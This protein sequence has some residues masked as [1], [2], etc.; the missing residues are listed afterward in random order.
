MRITLCTVP[1]EPDY[2]DLTPKVS[3]ETDV[4]TPS[5]RSEGQLPILPKIAIVSIVKWMESHGYGRETYDYYDIDM[6]LPSDERLERYFRDYQPAVVGLSAVVST[7]YAQVRRIS[8]ILRAAC[9]DAWIVLGGS[10]TASANLV[11]RKTDVDVCVVGDGEIAWV[12]FLDYVQV[13]GGKWNHEVLSKI[14]GLA[15]LD[16]KDELRMTGYGQ[17]IPAGDQPFPDYDILKLGLKDR[18]QDLNNFFRKGLGVTHFRSDPRTFEGHQRPNVAGLWSSKGCVARCTFC[19]RSTKGYRV[20]GIDALESHLITL[21]ERF[22]VGFIHIIDENFASDLN[23]AYEL[24]RTMKRHDM[25]WIASGV[26]VSSVKDEDVKFFKEHGCCCLKFGVETGSQKIMNVMEKKFTVERV[27]Q[28]LKHC[29]D[30]DMYSPLAVMV[31]MP[32]ETNETALATGRFV[33]RLSHMQGIEPEYQG[34]SIFYALPLTGTPLYVHGQQVGLIG[35]SPEEEE[36]YL[37]SVSGTG[38]SKVNYVNLNG[39]R[40]RDVVFWDWL[41]KLEASR[42]FFELDRQLPINRSRFFYRALVDEKKGEIVGRPLTIA[43]VVSKHKAG[44]RTGIKGRLFNAVDNFLDRHVVYNRRVLRLPRWLLFGAVKN[45]VFVIFLAQKFVVKMAGR[46]FN[47]Y[48][49]RPQV[50]PLKVGAQTGKVEIRTS[51]RT[52]VKEREAQR[53]LPDSVTEQNQDILAVGL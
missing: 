13:H 12:E 41:V 6:E 1:V 5:V 45:L 27:Y 50:A 19:Q 38:A 10:L 53:A 14:R 8:R 47:L 31:G 35:K 22:D 20:A 28:T 52:I 21:K 36:K 51:L 11:L 46:E 39:A 43:E 48:Q 3:Y 17:A 32:G 2:S 26:R 4:L 7:C 44:L 33:G 29:A 23:Y 24:A 25:L 40:M 30:L 49:P 42:T 16:E 9:P 34:L 15:F 18:P 37:L